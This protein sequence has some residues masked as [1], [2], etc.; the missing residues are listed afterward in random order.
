MD[1]ANDPELDGKYLGTITTDF[2]KVSDTLKEA[3]YQ[4]RVRKISEYP[5]FV[6]SKDSVNIGSL[7]IGK[8]E[9]DLLWNINFSFLENLIGHQIIAE[10][11]TEKFLATYKDPD[12]YACFLVMDKDF[13]KFIYIPYPVDDSISE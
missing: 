1:M 13:M 11:L 7:L 5:V 3:S 4:L 8:R 10:N 2:V 9:K 12:E 6:I